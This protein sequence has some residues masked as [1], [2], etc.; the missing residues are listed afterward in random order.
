MWK[1]NTILF[2]KNAPVAANDMY[3][4]SELHRLRRRFFMNYN[5]ITKVDNRTSMMTNIF[6][7]GILME[8][9][10]TTLKDNHIFSSCEV[11]ENVLLA[12][13]LKGMNSF[14]VIFQRK[15]LSNPSPC[16]FSSNSAFGSQ[17]K[18]FHSTNH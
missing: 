3:K 5:R 2:R 8:R 7:T 16:H 13:T 4:L 15:L 14:H 10:R 18:T 1:K 6:A 11:E 12:M 9:L 17:G